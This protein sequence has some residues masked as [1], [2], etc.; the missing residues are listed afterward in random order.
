[1]F[2]SPIPALVPDLPYDL[3]CDEGLPGPR[4]K[5]EEDPFPV[6]VNLLDRPVDCYLLIIPGSLPCNV[7]EG[8]ENLLSDVIRDSV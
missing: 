6:P 8:F 2:T 5:S 1:V 3:E 7:M 4:C